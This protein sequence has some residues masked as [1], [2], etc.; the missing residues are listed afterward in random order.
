MAGS[1]GIDEIEPMSKEAILVR[2]EKRRAGEQA[3]IHGV[4]VVAKAGQGDFGSLDRAAS[5]IGVLA[6][7][8][9]PA[10]TREMK[11]GGKA[12]DA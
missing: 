10:F 6:D 2:G 8:D 1:L 3:E 9:F 7:R 11:R 5:H 12:V 4:K